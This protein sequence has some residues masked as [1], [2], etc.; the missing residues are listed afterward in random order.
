[1]PKP[2]NKGYIVLGS[3]RATNGFKGVIELS[4]GM[5]LHDERANFFWTGTAH[6]IIG[7]IEL[8]GKKN[9]E[10]YRDHFSKTRP[11]MTFEVWDVDDPDLP[12][13]IDWDPFPWGQKAS[14]FNSRNLRF[15]MRE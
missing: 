12:V 6:T 8:D 15:D 10:Y 9:A 1:M 7:E 14:V 13:S 4:F 2:D 11:H 5:D 3:G